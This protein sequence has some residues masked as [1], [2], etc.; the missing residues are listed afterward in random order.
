MMKKLKVVTGGQ[1]KK[2]EP[3]VVPK[4]TMM[5]K[6]KTKTVT[7]E[8]KKFPEFKKKRVKQMKF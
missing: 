4:M 3:G 7:R 6:S 8:P 2:K 5:K 1:K